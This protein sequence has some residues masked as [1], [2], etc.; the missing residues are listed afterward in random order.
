MIFSFC[1]FA[2]LHSCTNLIVTKKASKEGYNSFTYSADAFS[3][4]GN[5]QVT[6]EA[7]HAEGEMRDIIDWC[8]GK[9]LGEIP[10]VAH[11]Y[12]VVGNMNEKGL[13]IG[14]TTWNGRT[15]ETHNPDGIMDYGSLI[16]VALERCSTARE[17]YQLVI[18]LAEKYGYH[19][20]GETFTIADKNEI[21]LLDLIGRG[22]NKKGILWIAT[23]IPD[24]MIAEHSNHPRTHSPY[25]MKQAGATIFW[26]DSLVEDCKELGFIS[27]DVTI[28]TFDWVLAVHGDVPQRRRYG[29]GRTVDFFHRTVSET[30]LGS[31]FTEYLAGSKEAAPPNLFYKPTAPLSLADLMSYMSLHFEDHN[32]SPV[33]DIGA[34]PFHSPYRSPPFNWYYENQQYVNERNIAT[35]QTTWVMIAQCRG[36]LPAALGGV[37]WFGMD[38]A[39]MAVYVPFFSTSRDVH[40]CY[41]ETDKQ[42]SQTFSF[43]SLF[44]VSNMISNFVQQNYVYMIDEVRQWR[45]QQQQRVISDF[46]QTLST[47]LS[48]AKRDEIVAKE[49]VTQKTILWGGQMLKESLDYYKVLF[50]RFAAG[51]RMTPIPGKPLPR[52]EWLPY[53]NKWYERIVKETGDKYIV[54]EDATSNGGAGGDPLRQLRYV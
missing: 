40:D 15:T 4:Y 9:K 21:W 35:P 24:G 34:G 2:T 22:P 50:P 51:Y 47:A 23:L 38:D 8:S 42:N 49:F 45:D 43:N 48:L 32:L 1:L 29:D 30:D 12:R 28:E 52:V 53:Q 31:D 20:Y 6:P 27:A 41:K 37:V 25:K 54:K 44:W 36:D 46:E 18:D 11:T 7:D 39:S 3:M 19:D 5:L 14:E 26:R 13:A 33:N 10:Q 16:Y 17:A